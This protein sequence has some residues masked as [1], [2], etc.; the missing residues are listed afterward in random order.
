MKR[1]A[2]NPKKP[3]I[4]NPWNPWFPWIL[5]LFTLTLK[6]ILLYPPNMSLTKDQVLHIAK[7]ARLQL[8]SEEIDKMTKELS[9]ILDYVKVLDEVDTATTEPTSQVTG[10][11]NAFREDEVRPSSATP[12]KLLE[13]SPLPIVDHQI[14][15]P[16]AHG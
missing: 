7:L 12:D 1:K 11:T 8:T 13:N 6:P 15:A 14:Q 5:F 9:S 2:R 16:H 3:R 10:L 4:Q